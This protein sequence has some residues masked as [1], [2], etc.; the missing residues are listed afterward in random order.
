MKSVFSAKRAELGRD[1]EYDSLRAVIAEYDAQ[2]QL[3]STH[4]SKGLGFR[5]VHL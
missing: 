3:Y 1:N 5:R 4:K 2:L